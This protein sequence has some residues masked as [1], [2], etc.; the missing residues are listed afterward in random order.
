VTHELRASLGVRVGS[1]LHGGQHLFDNLEIL[2]AELVGNNVQ[3]ADGVNITYK[4]MRRN[5]PAQKVKR[6][7]DVSHVTVL[8]DANDVVDTVDRLNVRQEVVAET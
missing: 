2:D 4:T 1:T 7:L 8:E 5:V 6:T 3:I